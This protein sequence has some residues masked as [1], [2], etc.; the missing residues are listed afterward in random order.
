M[1]RHCASLGELEL[2]SVNTATLQKTPWSLLRT[3]RCL[4]SCFTMVASFDPI[5]DW[6]G[7]DRDGDIKT[8]HPSF[9][10]SITHNASSNQRLDDFLGRDSYTLLSLW[11]TFITQQPNLR[12]IVI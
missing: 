11:I 5:G 8:L 10:H 1:R 7:F 12:T 6:A 9:C 4:S 2:D 3:G